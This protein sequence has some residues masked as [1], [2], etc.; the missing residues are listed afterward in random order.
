MRPRKR[1]ARRDAAP[2]RVRIDDGASAAVSRTYGAAAAAADEGSEPPDADHDDD[3]AD[4]Q[5]DDAGQQLAVARQP[6]TARD[7]FRL[8]ARG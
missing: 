3:D 7:E 6:L 8:R 2:E 1:N 5:Q 4:E